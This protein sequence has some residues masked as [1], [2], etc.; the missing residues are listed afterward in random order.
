MRADLGTNACANVLS[1]LLPVFSVQA[2][3]LIIFARLDRKI[4]NQLS[5]L[6]ALGLPTGSSDRTY[7]GFSALGRVLL[8]GAPLGKFTVFVWA[9]GRDQRKI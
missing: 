7:P 4:L 6:N 3:S 1:H 9:R 5:L 2:D 8:G